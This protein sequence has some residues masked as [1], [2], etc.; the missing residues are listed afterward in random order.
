MRGLSHC[1]NKRV[2]KVNIKP[3]AVALVVGLGYY[4]GVKKP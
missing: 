1:K 3:A 2:N 4:V